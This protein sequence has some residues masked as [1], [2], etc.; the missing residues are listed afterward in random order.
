MDLLEELLQDDD[1]DQ[2]DHVDHVD[3]DD[4]DDDLDDQDDHDHDGQRVYLDKPVQ[5]AGGASPGLA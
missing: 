5:S 1:H 3:H 4:H 2:G